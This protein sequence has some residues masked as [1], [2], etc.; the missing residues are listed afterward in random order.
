MISHILYHYIYIYI[1][2]FCHSIPTSTPSP[3]MCRLFTRGH[4]TSCWS[5]TSS[6]AKVPELIFIRRAL[7]SWRHCTNGTPW[8][9]DTHN[10]TS[11]C[12]FFFWGGDDG[13][14]L[15]MFIVFFWFVHVMFSFLV[16]LPFCWVV[17]F[18]RF[19]D[20]YRIWSMSPC[21]RD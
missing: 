12:F 1:P 5:A 20:W 3:T 21:Q 14:C 7:R 11:P 15:Y 13:A 17:F 19:H 2:F 9:C 6:M 10:G 4:G 18:L 8:W 16:C